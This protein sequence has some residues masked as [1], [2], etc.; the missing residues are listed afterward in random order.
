LK[1]GWWERSKGSKV[2]SGDAA[3][4]GSECV[5]ELPGWWTRF[6]VPFSLFV[7]PSLALLLSYKNEF[8]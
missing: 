8:V 6:S 7:F 4:P 3:R 2:A 1:R 5:R